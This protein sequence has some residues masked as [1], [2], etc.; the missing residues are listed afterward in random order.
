[1]RISKFKKL[2]WDKRFL[3]AYLCVLV[4]AIISGIVLFKIGS[5]STYVYNFADNY[6]YYIFDFQNGKLFVSHILTEIFYLYV[7]FVIAYFTKLRFLCVAVMFVRTVF[8]VLYT[9]ILLSF[10]GAEG[11]IIALL[12]L[13]PTFCVSFIFFIFISEQCKIFTAP[14]VFIIPAFLALFNTV[15]FLFSVNVLFRVIVVIV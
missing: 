5:I 15:I 8:V 6:V 12:V 13:L 11:I 10:F 4:L 7:A 2:K 14:F 3:I 9:A 1:M